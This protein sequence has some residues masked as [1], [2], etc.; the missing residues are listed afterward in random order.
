[1]DFD[2]DA[3]FLLRSGLLCVSDY[4]R[5]SASSRLA[6]LDQASQAQCF[7]ASRPRGSPEEFL[8]WARVR[9]YPRQMDMP[10]LPDD[11]E[12]AIEFVWECGPRVSAERL[13]RMLLLERVSQRLEPI[14]SVLEL[15]MSDAACDIACAMALD[16]ARRANP[17]ATM[18]S[19]GG[20]IFCV[21]LGLFAAI[22]DAIRWL[23][24]R[25]I[26]KLVYGF[27]SV[28]DMPD[29]GVREPIERPPDSVFDK[30]AACSVSWVF[31]CRR[32]V[33]SSARRDPARAHACY[34]Q[35][36]QELDAGLFM[37]L[38]RPLISTRSPARG[39]TLLGLVSGGRSPG[40]QF[41]RALSE[42]ASTTRLFLV[43]PRRV[44]TRM[45]RFAAVDPMPLS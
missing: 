27:R 6:P 7:G 5:P 35:S 8:E 9:P 15:P 23:D 3:V 29:S 4:R 37:G 1:M 28:C 22:V 16:I 36:L 18:E 19:L 42:G 40:S 34:Q 26:Y 38:S 12:A 41:G 45:R 10:T 14:S 33:L 21:H 43:L 2:F 17:T 24:R 20:A 13:R 25:L 11:L 39:S 44:P 32:R 31:E 30:F